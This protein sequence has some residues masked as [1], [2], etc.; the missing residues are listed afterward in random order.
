VNT[1]MGKRNSRAVDRSYRNLGHARHGAALDD[2][3]A[4]GFRSLRAPGSHF[5]LKTC[6]S[7]GQGW[8]GEGSQGSGV[9]VERQAKLGLITKASA[10]TKLSISGPA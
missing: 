3:K 10:T 5:L 1:N 2:L 6:S 4:I 9:E 8:L 7:Q